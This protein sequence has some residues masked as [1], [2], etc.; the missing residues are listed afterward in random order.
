MRNFLG[1]LNLFSLA[2][3]LFISPPGLT[4]PQ[5]QIV[6][7][8]DVFVQEGDL[9][10]TI[11]NQFYGDASAYAAIVE[12][13]N[14]KAAVDDSYTRID[15]VDRLTVGW[16]L[17]VP[18]PVQSPARLDQA[19]VDQAAEEPA[20]IELGGIDPATINP[21]II[22]PAAIG[23]ATGLSSSA[24]EEATGL[25][26]LFIE[27]GRRRDYPGSEVVIEETLSGGGNFNRYLV[28]YQS[29]GLK[30]YGLLAIPNGE[31]PATGW[32]VIIFNHG[33]ILPTQY[34]ATVYYVDHVNALARNG[35][36]VFQPD[37]RGHGRSEGEATGLYMTPDYVTDVLNTLASIKRHPQ[38]D[39]DRIG[40]W[41][42]SMGGYVTLRAMVT[43]DEVKA[44]V[45][46]AGVVGSY[47]EMVAWWDVRRSFA[48][49]EPREWR[50]AIVASYGNWEENPAFWAAISANTYL[51]DLS[52]PLQLHHSAT[53]GVVPVAFSNTL[54]EQLQAA[55]KVVEYYV[56]GG[57]DH[58]LS[59][60]F[61]PAMSRSV[62]F[63][64]QYVKGTVR[65]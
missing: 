26:P 24:S 55:G 15:D 2:A 40:M 29:D 45:I 28:S 56:Y 43:T 20:A 6:C 35:Y 53:D 9:L 19:A 60:S 54:D 14:T 33:Y 59:A 61:E 18:G 27:S 32:P 42:H 7:S 51:A 47:E 50:D 46:W 12:A 13:T 39:P 65:P 63:F 25:H 48:L 31:R 58:N 30:I 16:K 5:S 37:Y 36:M 8:A 21:A 3:F 41:G 17:C 38:A 49:I 44:G 11:A 23:L 10:S 34:N 22:M 62:A 4:P 57:D 1:M 52:G 64:D